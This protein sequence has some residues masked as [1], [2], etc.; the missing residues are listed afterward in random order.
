V[1]IILTMALPF[2]PTANT[3]WRKGPKGWYPS[4]AYLAWRVEAG[5]WL[6][7]QKE[8]DKLVLP[9][10]PWT[11]P[12][13][14]EARLNPPVKKD[15]KPRKRVPDLDNVGSKAILDQL[16]RWEVIADDDQ[17][18]KITMMWDR[19]SGPPG[20]CILTLWK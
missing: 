8:R 7:H 15:G 19:N 12:C 14:F 5:R 16:V 2:P 1:S 3:L 17:L 11:E 4:K 6:M 10:E 13:S 9:T 20:S 18:Q